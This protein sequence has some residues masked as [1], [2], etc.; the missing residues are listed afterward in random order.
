MIRIAPYYFCL[1]LFQLLAVTPLFAQPKCKIEHYSTEEGLSHDII[2][3]IFKDREGFMWFGTWNGINRFDGQRFVT[4][5]SFPGDQSSIKNNRFDQIMEDDFLHLWIRGYDGQIYRFN[6][7]TEKMLPLS[8]VVKL[9]PRNKYSFSRILSTT[10]G[11]IWIETQNEGLL[12]VTSPQADSSAY[13]TYQ[14]GLSKE[15]SLP[16]NQILFF[17]E[18]KNG[19]I[20]V[21]TQKGLVCLKK[22][23]NGIYKNVPVDFPPGIG[24]TCMATDEHEIAYWFGTSDGRF[25]SKQPNGSLAGYSISTSAIQEILV[26]KDKTGL[27]ITTAGGEL[28]SLTVNHLNSISFNRLIN[29]P[30]NALRT[31]YEDHTG[32]IWVQPQRE[33]VI[34]IDP[35]TGKKKTYHQ[36]NNAKYNYPGDHFAIFEDNQQRIWVNLKGGGFGYYDSVKDNVEYFYNEPNAPN[37]QFSNIVGVLYYDTTGLLWLRTDDR[38]V[39]KITFQRN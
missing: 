30:G 38:G 6:K 1:L 13:Y 9:P 15:F 31:I 26:K 37:H 4:Y 21:G 34:R 22:D 12:L 19:E 33:G 11:R 16:S 17:K 32:H 5:K 24:Y 29:E 7:R 36:Q 28:L 20:W 25:F 35:V 39:E 27:F 18:L 23:K 8:S 3:C 2:T 14:E 10:R